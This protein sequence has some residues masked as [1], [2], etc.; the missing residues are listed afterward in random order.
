MESANNI[1]SLNIEY[2]FKIL[3][4]LLVHA[5]VAGSGISY[6]VFLTNAWMVVTIFSY[7]ISLFALGALVY[8]NM[9][10]HQT[11]QEEEEKL[12]SFK[13]AEA[14]VAVEHSRW[15]HVESLIEGTNEHEWRQAII[16]ADIMLDDILRSHGYQGD[17]IGEKL[18]QADPSRF[19]TLQDAWEAHKVRN[20]IAHQGSNYQLSEQMAHRT[21][22]HYRNVFLEFHAI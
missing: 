3:Y 6:G 10:M 19:H 15:R 11:V 5:K 7:L 2:F 9:R 4:D 16:E 21:I 18:K 14:E 20:E 22:L 12:A 13:P 8:Y 17:S 1:H